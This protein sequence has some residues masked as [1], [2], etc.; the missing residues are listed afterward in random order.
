MIIYE[1]LVSA[2]THMQMIFFIFK[3]TTWHCLGSARFDLR[4]KQM[5][6]VNTCSWTLSRSSR[7]SPGCKKAAQRKL[8]N[9]TTTAWKSIQTLNDSDRRWANKI[10]HLLVNWQ[11]HTDTH[12]HAQYMLER[13]YECDFSKSA[14][15]PLC[16]VLVDATQRCATFAM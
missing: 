3:M 13:W 10:R 5:N 12:T 4:N 11:I 1:Q 16:I 9:H 8:I 2:R 6:A 15:R 14:S 7:A